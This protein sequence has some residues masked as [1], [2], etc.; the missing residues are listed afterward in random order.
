MELVEQDPRISEL[1]RSIR[2]LRHELTTLRQQEEQCREQASAEDL[3][4]GLKQLIEMTNEVV[5][6]PLRVENSVDP[7][8][9]DTTHV[10]FH[11]V[12]QNRLDDV[13]AVIDAEIEWHRRARAIFAEATCHF[14]LA[15]ER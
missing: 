2:E 12:P 10:V 4:R 1:E 9:P 6:G 3:P 7:E 5:P 13:H 8:Y 15:I 11:V 14:R